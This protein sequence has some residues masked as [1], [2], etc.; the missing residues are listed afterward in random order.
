MSDKRKE[1]IAR[2]RIN[3]AHYGRDS[4]GL[5]LSDKAR[6]ELLRTGAG[7]LTEVIQK[8][9]REKKRQDLKQRLANRKAKHV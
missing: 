6:E 2:G 9:N 8:R 7:E 1:N 5:R 3:F 4:L